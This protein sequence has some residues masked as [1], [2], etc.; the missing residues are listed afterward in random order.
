MARPYSESVVLRRSPDER[1]RRYRLHPAF[2]DE[3]ARRGP[4]G[5][6]LRI[7]IAV[8]RLVRLAVVAA[9]VVGGERQGA[10]RNPS[11]I[12]HQVYGR[13][14]PAPVWA[15]RPHVYDGDRRGPRIDP[16]RAAPRVL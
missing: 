8:R 11:T 12:L 9:R 15:R 10:P 13:P 1:D 16:R 3:V 7:G 4:A 5:G 6:L 14:P 2:D